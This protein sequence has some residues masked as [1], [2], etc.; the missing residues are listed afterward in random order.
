MEKP[1]P[2]VRA[3]LMAQL[4]S[5]PSLPRPQAKRRRILL[6]ALAALP[7][8]VAVLAYGI[9]WDGRPQSLVLVSF[10]AAIAVAGAGTWWA[11]I[12]GQSTLGR[13]R[14]WLRVAALTIP[15]V[16]M[17][18]A[19]ASAL[20]W[21]E[22]QVGL[23]LDPR[24]HIPCF[25]MTFLLA[26]APFAAMMYLERRSDPVAPAATGALLGASAGSW[27]GVTMTLKCAD[28]HLLH[29]GL[30]H[31]LPLLGL[32]VLGALVGSR[33]VAMRSDSKGR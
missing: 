6:L 31:V 17:V 30:A 5:R 11:M 27:A 12:P 9:A 2:E 3:R 29:V 23:S 24:S 10:A 15:A 1:S 25:A 33:V 4:A 26:A 28:A 32:A 8:I 7:P 20:V 16:L 19:I 22:T 21:P 18:V 14:P 13:P